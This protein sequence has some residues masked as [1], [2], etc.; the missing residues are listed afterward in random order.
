ML[1]LEVQ[2]DVCNPVCR[3]RGGLDRLVSIHR[4]AISNPQP[5]LGENNWSI[6]APN[7]SAVVRINSHSHYKP[8]CQL[9]FFG[10]L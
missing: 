1:Q 5:S 8:N 10:S 2:L 9:S 7:E 6:L 4:S 3:T